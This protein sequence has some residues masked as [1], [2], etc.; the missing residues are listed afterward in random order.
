MQWLEEHCNSQNHEVEDILPVHHA[1]HI[2]RL[3]A[4]FLLLIDI[5]FF[6]KTLLIESHQ[7]RFYLGIIVMLKIISQATNLVEQKVSFLSYGGSSYVKTLNHMQWIDR[8]EFRIPSDSSVLAPCLM[9]VHYSFSTLLWV[10]FML[11]VTVCCVIEVPC[12]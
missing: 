5:W 9:F 11:E 4:R 7:V 12:I 6:E 3:I 2:H 1:E 10:T 8:N